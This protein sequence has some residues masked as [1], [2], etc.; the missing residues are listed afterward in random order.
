[1]RALDALDARPRRSG[2]VGRTGDRQGGHPE[3]D[4]DALRRDR[5]GGDRLRR[6]QPRPAGAAAAGCPGPRR[7]RGRR[8]PPLLLEDLLGQLPPDTAGPV[9]DLG[10]AAHGFL[11]SEGG[12][13]VG[14]GGGVHRGPAR[15]RNAGAAGPTA[16]PHQPVQH[17]QPTPHATR[18]WPPSPAEPNWSLLAFRV[19][20]HGAELADEIIGCGGN[21]VRGRTG[22][23]GWTRFWRAAGCCGPAPSGGCWTRCSPSY[24][25]EACPTLIARWR[26]NGRNE[27]YE[28]WF[29]RVGW[30]Q[31]VDADRGR[32]DLRRPH[33]DTRWR[34]AERPARGARRLPRQ[35]DL[36]RLPPARP[37]PDPRHATE[38]TR[39]VVPGGIARL[40][41]SDED[42][43]VVRA[44]FGLEPIGERDQPAVEVAPLWMDERLV[45]RDRFAAYLRTLPAHRGGGRDPSDR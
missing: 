9:T 7:T 13:P 33:R 15:R 5:S 29:E 38:R 22:R 8:H 21:R 18:S 20:Y 42:V 41:L 26:P 3:A 34:D 14:A 24:A 44:V 19:I 31:E 10:P 30:A 1:M 2:P 45:S 39:Y 32:M 35:E 11:R 4:P 43:D 12:R 25:D 36:R 27:A 16:R 17:D 37:A 6:R 23:P 28:R 40:G